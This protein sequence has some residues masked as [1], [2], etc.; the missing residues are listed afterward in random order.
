M[1]YRKSIRV[2]CHK[3][4]APLAEEID[5]SNDFPSELW[6]NLEIWVC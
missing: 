1:L 3:E 2:F 6:K 5:K 4:I